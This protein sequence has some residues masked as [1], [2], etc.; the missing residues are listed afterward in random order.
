M[1]HGIGLTGIHQG[2]RDIIEWKAYIIIY[3]YIILYIIIIMII[4]II[5]II[6]SIIIDSMEN[7]RTSS[8]CQT[9]T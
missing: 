2:P 6:D 4:F 8:T 7:L 9:V 1:S 5:I 3:H